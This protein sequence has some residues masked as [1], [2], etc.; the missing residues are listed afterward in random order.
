MKGFKYLVISTLFV[1]RHSSKLPFLAVVVLAILLTTCKTTTTPKLKRSS[2]NVPPKRELRAVW[3]ATV[4]NID[5]PSNRNLSPDQQRKEFI[6]LIEAHKK[7]GINAVFVQV[8]A[9]ADAFYGKGSEPWSEWLTGKQGKAPEPYYDPMEFMIEQC[10]DRGIEFHAWLNLNRVA[11][12]SSKTFATNNV[13]KLHPDWIL[14]YD[15]YKLF[16]FGLPQVRDYITETTFNIVRNYDVDGIHFDDYF[17]PYTVAGQTLKDDDAYKQYGQQFNKNNWRRNNIDVLIKQIADG[18]VAIKPFVKFGISPFG[19]W[20]NKKDDKTGSDTQAGQTSYDNLFADTK[21]WTKAGW[22]DY[23]MPQIYF[24]TQF[25]KVPFKTLTSWWLDNR[26][27]RHLYI[28]QGAYRVGDP[29]QNDRAWGDG[30][31]MANQMRFL[32]TQSGVN[33]SVFFSSKSLINN[34]LGFTDSL[35]AHFYQYP[36][37]P[38]TMAW[39]DNVPPLPPQNLKI[40]DTPQ[41]LTLA[42]KTAPTAKDGEK[43]RYYAIYR[44]DD[45]EAIDLSDPR[46]FLTFCYKSTTV[47]DQTARKNKSYVY[48]VTALDRLHNESA[49]VQLKFNVKNFVRAD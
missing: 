15:S 1:N 18:I 40:E 24:S 14:S 45:T 44:F 9:A 31:E 12:K 7:T 2:Q 4:E 11:N 28:G 34:K 13:G 10:H 25:D 29:K 17:Y 23:M 41:N 6:A 30:S 42:W 21:K 36:A 49:P 22:I 3:I 27:G 26:N 46:H 37:L 19:V 38:P 35:K 47:T 16:N 20:R 8:R 48:V 5:W 33:G 39:K 32:R 43:A